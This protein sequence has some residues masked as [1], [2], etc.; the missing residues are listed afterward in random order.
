MR[1]IFLRIYLGILLAV[2]VLGAGAYGLYDSWHNKRLQ[3]YLIDN[4]RG[5]VQLIAEGLQRHQGERREQWL[6]LSRRVTGL[7]IELLPTAQH[8]S[9]PGPLQRIENSDWS[10]FSHY[11]DQQQLTL[12]LSNNSAQ[13]YA[14]PIS[15]PDIN[16]QLMRGTAL[17]ILNELGRHGKEQR[18]QRLARLQ[19]HFHYPLSWLKRAQVTANYLQKRALSRGNSVVDFTTGTDGKQSMRTLAP[20]GNSGDYLQLGPVGLYQPFPLELIYLSAATLLILLAATCF[21]LVRPLEKRLGRMAQ[22]VD[23]LQLSG[24]SSQLTVDGNDALTALAEKI[25]AMSQR[26][27]QLLQHQRELNHAVSHELKT[28]LARLTFRRELALQKLS[29][30]AESGS[31]TKAVAQH[32]EGME[33]SLTE[34]NSLVEE[35]LLYARLES[36]APEMNLSRVKVAVLCDELLQPLRSQFSEMEFS[37]DI[38]ADIA[39]MADQHY[40][41]RALSN[42]INNA[43]RFADNQVSIVLEQRPQQ[44]I[45]HID[46]D[47]QGIPEEHWQSVLQ[48]FSRVESSRNRE[49]GG[50]GLGL[51]IVQ[52]IAEWHQGDIRVS[53]APLGGARLS[54]QI[55]LQLN[56]VESPAAAVKD[57]N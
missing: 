7:Q 36:T 48:P 54:L 35:I 45:I 13:L 32:L 27:L 52:Q 31:D 51:A 26:I 8:P 1:S 55:P 49:T 46:D 40:L 17:L 30:L 34:L 19:V 33:T 5:S 22:E 56:V 21:L 16:E 3:Q 43:Q 6:S 24:Q 4:S 25:N 41:K 37:H 10:M 11:D 53:R 20:I 23:A 42:L 29:K 44:L 15:E 50:T 14:I 2:V 47:G 38:P 18:Q 12:Y 9:N 28:P 39:L 57:T